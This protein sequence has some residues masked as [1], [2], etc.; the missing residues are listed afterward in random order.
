MNGI[1]TTFSKSVISDKNFY[2]THYQS[3]PR[4]TFQKGRHS[5]WLYKGTNVEHGSRISPRE[6]K[7]ENKKEISKRTV[8]E[9]SL[10][11]TA[12][13]SYFY[14]GSLCRKCCLIPNARH[15]MYLSHFYAHQA[16]LKCFPFCPSFPSCTPA[17]YAITESPNF[18][19]FLIPASL[20]LQC[21]E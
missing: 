12:Q 20:F 14:T 11:R 8:S 16:I 2:I 17:S 10:K 1:S 3:K 18:L 15:L 19:N 4:R 6:N 7:I 13:A 21:R 9:I 5:T